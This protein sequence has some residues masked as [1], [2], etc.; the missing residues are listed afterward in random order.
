MCSIQFVNNSRRKRIIVIGTSVVS[1]QQ[2]SGYCLQWGAEV[3]PYY[4]IPNEEEICLFKP[5]I[6]VLCLPIPQN[7]HLPTDAVLIIWEEPSTVLQA[8]ST[9]AELI[10]CL[11]RLAQLSESDDDDRIYAK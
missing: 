9:R 4:G 11:D 8:I 10:L 1:V 3:L 6:W 2:V 5:H 7:L